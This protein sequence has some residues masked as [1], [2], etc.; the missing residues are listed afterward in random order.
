MLAKWA[1]SFV[2]VAKF[3]AYVALNTRKKIAREGAALTKTAN[4]FIT[5]YTYE[6]VEKSSRRLSGSHYLFT[7]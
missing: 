6:L 5:D 3:I 2:S 1:K 4:A 7:H